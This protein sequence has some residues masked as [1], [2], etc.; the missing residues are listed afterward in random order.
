ML[1][2]CSMFMRK[3]ESK[4]YILQKTF[5]LLM[6]KGY[7]GVSIS[8]IKNETGMSRGLL[9]HYF[10]SKDELFRAVGETFLID[11]FMTYPA[12]TVDYTLSQMIDYVVHRYEDIYRGWNDYLDSSIITMANYDFLVY[13]MIAKDK[14]IADRYREMRRKEA[15]A[16]GRAVDRSMQI[17][18][19]R[20]VL[21]RERLV[22]HLIAL[23]DGM[24]TQAVEAGDKNRYI[25]QL[26]EVLIDY[27]QLLKG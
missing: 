13:Q 1:N 6:T 5:Y 14:Q 21:T 20:P 7:D 10:K 12:H 2:D 3:P 17:G 8:D 25:D 16:W 27:Y 19:I 18:D 23:L 26:E 11:M 22:R 15:E 9:Y 4:D 24:W